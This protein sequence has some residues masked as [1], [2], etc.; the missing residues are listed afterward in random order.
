MKVLLHTLDGS[1]V[2]YGCAICVCDLIRKYCICFTG[3]EKRVNKHIN[4]KRRYDI[5][6]GKKSL[7]STAVRMVLDE[8]TS[9]CCVTLDEDVNP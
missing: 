2:D 7:M 6:M 9:A 1:E 4:T 5:Y 8:S 3:D